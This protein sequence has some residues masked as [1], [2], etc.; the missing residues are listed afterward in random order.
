MYIRRYISYIYWWLHEVD[1]NWNEDYDTE[2]G[3]PSAQTHHTDI[4][5]FPKRS[6]VSTESADLLGITE[7][8]RDI[9]MYPLKVPLWPTNQFL[10]F[11]GFQ[12]YAN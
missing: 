8:G 9:C 5:S 4:N 2:W 7:T 12:K 3:S 1:C 6:R 10:F 11:F